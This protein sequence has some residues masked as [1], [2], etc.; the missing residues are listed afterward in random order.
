MEA[1]QAQR[2]GRVDLQEVTVVQGLEE[3]V[4]EEGAGGGTHLMTA[5]RHEV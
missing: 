1:V 2:G 5:R 4:D 3:R